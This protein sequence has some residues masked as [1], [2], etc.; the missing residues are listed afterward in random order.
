MKSRRLLAIGLTTFIGL[1]CLAEDD[2]PQQQEMQTGWVVTFTQPG[3]L[4]Y[5]GYAGQGALGYTGYG[6]QGA[7]GYSG[8][9]GQ[10]ALGYSGYGGSMPSV[11]Y[12]PAA[13]SDPTSSSYDPY[14]V[15]SEG[16][17]GGAYDNPSSSY[18]SPSFD[19]LGY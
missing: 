16:W 14:E 12:D 9:G 15:D 4:G 11:N 2:E 3:A 18:Y 1:A 10:G 8:Y 5:A 6:G 19:S 17:S 13:Y 7:L